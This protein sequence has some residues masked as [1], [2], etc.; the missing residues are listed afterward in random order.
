MWLCFSKTSSILKTNSYSFLM[1]QNDILWFFFLIAWKCI[2]QFYWPARAVVTKCHKL[3]DLK[4]IASGFWMPEVR[5]RGVHDW[6]PPRNVRK[7]ICSSLSPWVV[8]GC[9]LSVHVSV[10]KFP[11]D[12]VL[13][14]PKS[15][16]WFNYLYMKTLYIHIRSHSDIL[17]IGTSVCLFFFFFEGGVGDSTV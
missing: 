16:F 10:Y 1:L 15:S 2:N 14:H 9:L 8:D 11:C 7:G 6:F 4:F 12:V 3:C 13:G 17:R 5:N